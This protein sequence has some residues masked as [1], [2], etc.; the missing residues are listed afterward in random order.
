MVLKQQQHWNQS[1][2]ESGYFIDPQGEI[3]FVTDAQAKL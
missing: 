3:V 1:E 2:S